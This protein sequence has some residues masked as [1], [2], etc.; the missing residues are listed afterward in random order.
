MPVPDMCYASTGHAQ[1]QYRTCAMPVGRSDLA[2]RALRQPLVR[3]LSLL[4]LSLFPP[5]PLS[6]SSNPAPYRGLIQP[7]DLV[8]HTLHISTEIT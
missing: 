5:F 2:S 8:V 1:C 7:F 4:S 6:P 3:S